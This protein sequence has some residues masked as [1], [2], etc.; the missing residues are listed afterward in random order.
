M[1]FSEFQNVISDSPHNYLHHYDA[2][3]RKINMW[4]TSYLPVSLQYF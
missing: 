4:L 3:R 2:L 1:I